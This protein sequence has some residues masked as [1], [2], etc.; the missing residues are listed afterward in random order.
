[1]A[2][3]NTG[4]TLLAFAL[5]IVAGVVAGVLLAPASG[6]ETREHVQDWMRSAKDR[7]EGYLR[8]KRES[9][10]AQKEALAAAYEAGKKAYREAGP[11]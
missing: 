1:M 9:L 10:T 11:S 3:N 2:E 8:S 5:G 6:E 4:E 7:S